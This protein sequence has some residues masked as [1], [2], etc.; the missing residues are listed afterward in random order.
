VLRVGGTAGALGACT[1]GGHGTFNPLSF[2]GAAPAFSQAVALLRN[3]GI[4]RPMPAIPN[5]YCCLVQPRFVTH[6][7]CPTSGYFRPRFVLHAHAAGTLFPMHLR[8]TGLARVGQATNLRK[9]PAQVAFA[10]TALLQ[11]VPHLA[12][13]LGIKRNCAL[14]TLYDACVGRLDARMTPP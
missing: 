9:L 1:Q 14:V 7:P 12:A 5:L 4:K 2:E 11:S 8:V 10:R 13:L 3:R 6:P